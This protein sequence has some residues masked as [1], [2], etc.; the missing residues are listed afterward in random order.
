MTQNLDAL[1][2][3]EGFDLRLES[4]LP[5]YDLKEVLGRESIEMERVGLG[6]WSVIPVNIDDAGHIVLGVP[7]ADAESMGV[8]VFFQSSSTLT[9]ELIAGILLQL[10]NRQEARFMTPDGALVS[11][12]FPA[13]EPEVQGE[14][15]IPMQGGITLQ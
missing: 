13:T 10:L 5:L 14:S 8:S 2:R 7:R 3:S 9:S 15:S 6:S 1:L 4:D 11:P 12:L